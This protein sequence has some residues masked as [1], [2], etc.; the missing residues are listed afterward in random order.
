MAR[1]SYYRW[2][3]RASRSTA[4]YPAP[5]KVFL[6]WSGEPSKSIAEALYDWLPD[7]IQ[8]AEPFFS[9]ESLDAGSRW[10]SD[11]D[12][13]LKGSIGIICLTPNNLS[14]PWLNYEAGA[15]S[16]AVPE[17]PVRVIPLLHGL[18]PRDVKPPMSQF[19][20]TQLNAEGLLQIVKTLN[21]VATRQLDLR[22]LEGSFKRCW[23]ELESAI[24]RLPK[25][26]D[27]A[28][29]KRDPSDVLSEILDV[30]RD[31]QKSS[32]IQRQLPASAEETMRLLETTGP[33]GTR[34]DVLDAMRA[35]GVG[36][37]HT[38]LSRAAGRRLAQH[39][40][41]RDA[42]RH[43]VARAQAEAAV[44]QKTLD[45]AAIEKAIEDA[46]NK[47]SALEGPTDTPFS[48]SE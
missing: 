27:P 38:D 33:L 14:A 15:L 26:A 12:E 4:S 22:R 44:A 45:N 9:S 23:P 43:Q 17:A 46:I 3:G 39:Q 29:V 34:L 47:R 36:A 1:R 13:E 11:L 28:P 32:H 20:M 16:K 30:V 42:A 31:L 2:R 7:V 6:S 40:T 10:L 48:P 35:A 21:G 19:N 5:V 18:E 8:E 24:S 25:V 41:E 37:A